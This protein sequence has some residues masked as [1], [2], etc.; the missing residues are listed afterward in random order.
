V[1]IAAFVRIAT[2][3]GI[4]AET[5]TEASAASEAFLAFL[6]TV[7]AGTGM[8]EVARVARSVLAHPVG[9]STEASGVASR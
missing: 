4:V 2:S 3:G 7:E 6:E 1:G 9:S 5:G 8:W